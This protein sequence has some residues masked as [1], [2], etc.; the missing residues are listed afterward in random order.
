MKFGGLEAYDLGNSSLDFV[1]DR[2]FIVELDAKAN[3]GFWK[4]EWRIYCEET[5]E[6]MKSIGNDNNYAY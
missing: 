6:Q 3:F 4:I 1:A 5:H 2:T